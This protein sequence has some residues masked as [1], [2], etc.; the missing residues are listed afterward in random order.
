MQCSRKN[1][2]KT[3]AL[4]SFF[5]C[6]RN[7]LE[8]KCVFLLFRLRHI[9]S[10][11][12]APE[13]RRKTASHDQEES[14]APAFD[15]NNPDKDSKVDH[16][17]HDGRV[18][19]PSSAGSHSHQKSPARISSPHRMSDSELRER[20]AQ[21]TSGHESGADSKSQRSTTSSGVPVISGSKATLSDIR[22]SSSGRSH[23]LKAEDGGRKKEKKKRN[24]N[25]PAGVNDRDLELFGQSQEAARDFLARENSRL[26]PTSGASPSASSKAAAAD[27]GKAA[28]DGK[29]NSKQDPSMHG[30]PTQVAVPHLRLGHYHNFIL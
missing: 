17:S 28:G 4:S 27:D 18:R 8:L 15:N 5:N 13:K 23:L 14:G 29:A 30:V 12:Y 2:Q 26:L 9:P 22:I 3:P 16:G 10:H 7:L 24:Q 1:D 19:H 20:E 6:I 21:L 25:L 11:N